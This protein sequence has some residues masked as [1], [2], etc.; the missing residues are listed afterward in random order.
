MAPASSS[1]IHKDSNIYSI[2][3]AILDSWIYRYVEQRNY[4]SSDDSGW[5]ETWCRNDHPS[6]KASCCNHGSNKSWSFQVRES[7][8]YKLRRF[9]YHPLVSRMTKPK[10]HIKQLHNRSAF[11]C[12]LHASQVS[13][14]RL[15]YLFIINHN[16]FPAPLVPVTCNLCYP[17]I[18]PSFPAW[19]D[20]LKHHYTVPEVV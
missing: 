20:Y 10:K 1:A 4:N 14:K 9:L 17:N 11:H 16:T 3:L 13:L 12:D 15:V 2:T 6:G 19:S 5:P 18:P 7:I 8:V